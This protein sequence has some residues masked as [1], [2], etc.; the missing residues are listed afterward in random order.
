MGN[1]IDILGDYIRVYLKMEKTMLRKIA[2]I[3]VI[4]VGIVAMTIGCAG[5]D[6]LTPVPTAS[7]TTAPRYTPTSVPIVT[8]TIPTHT[9]PTPVPTATSTP[10]VV[11]APDGTSYGPDNIAYFRAVV[12]EMLA[13]I[14]SNA[15]NP[16]ELP[17]RQQWAARFPPEGGFSAQWGAT[18]HE[19]AEYHINRRSSSNA[20]H[21]HTIDGYIDRIIQTPDGS[22]DVPA[23]WTGWSLEAK[24]IGLKDIA[25]E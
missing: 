12:T 24:F 8:A 3:I 10:V 13:C 5:G 1:L 21:W 6:T 18:T 25:C 9:T 23:L 2:G 15:L 14:Y 4:G 7:Q 16:D 20:D 22:S 17:F 11:V 19:L